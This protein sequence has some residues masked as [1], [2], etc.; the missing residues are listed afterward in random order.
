LRLP[1]T[2]ID[3]ISVSS[4]PNSRPNGP[5]DSPRPIEEAGA[6]ERADHEHVAVGEVDQ[7]DDPVDER[8]ADGD[9]RPDGAVG[10]ALDEVV[11]QVGEVVRGGRVTVGE[12]AVPAD[13][14][15][16]AAIDR[17]GGQARN[18]TPAAKGPANRRQHRHVGAEPRRSGGEGVG[19]HE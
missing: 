17:E 12:A 10:D 9:Q 7:L 14:V 18:Q 19:F 8:V 4:S 6:G 2:N 5:V 13:E 15:V 3:T 11:A 1:H 16:D